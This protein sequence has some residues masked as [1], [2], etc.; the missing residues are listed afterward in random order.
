MREAARILRR[1]TESGALLAIGVDLDKAVVVRNR[2]DGKTVRTAVVDH[3]IARAFVRRG[4][5]TC[6]GIDKVFRCI[7]TDSGRAALRRLL[8]DHKECAG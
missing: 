7:I 3:R 1:L 5:V 4:W 2:P 8:S 6:T